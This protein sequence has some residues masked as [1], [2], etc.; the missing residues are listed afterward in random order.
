MGQPEGFV[1][2]TPGLIDADGVITNDGTR[3]FLQGYLETFLALVGRV[4][5]ARAA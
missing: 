2:V 3:A 4:Q 5:K 1:Q